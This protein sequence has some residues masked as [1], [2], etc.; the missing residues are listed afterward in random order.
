VPV[1]EIGK[2]APK[3]VK[4]APSRPLALDLKVSAPQAIF[5]RGKGLDAEVGGELTVTGTSAKPSVI[6]GLSMRR[7]TY[8]LLGKPL[9]F[10]R[11]VVTFT[12]ADRIEPVLDMLARTRGDNVTVEVKVTGTASNPKIELSSSPTLPQDEI[13]AHLLFGK[14]ASQLGPGELIAVANA[15]GEL[16]GV[17]SSTT[18][19]DSVRQAL[20][21]DRLGIG[22]GGGQ[23]GS[24]SSGSG[25]GVSGA[26]V[27]GGRYI[28]RGVY[29][30]GR[31][32]LQGDSRGVVQIEVIPHVKIEAEVGT[33]ST[34]RAGV[35]LEYDY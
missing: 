20:G 28:G 19:I 10:S 15:V 11:G 24:S 34:G 5:V 31:Q 2:G 30:G 33:N 9:N 1:R 21:L 18:A 25:G 16:S 22:Q 14:G 13:I 4:S 32:G 6:G 7:G 8:T 23:Q 26:G 17:G 27:E 35:A 29:L 12:N 3:A